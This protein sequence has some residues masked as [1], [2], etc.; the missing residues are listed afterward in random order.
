MTTSDPLLIYDGDCGVCTRAAHWVEARSDV[1]IR[2][3]EDLT[4]DET[5]R[6][7]TDWRQ[8]AHFLVGDRV[9]SCG[10]AMERAYARTDHVGTPLL[11]V[12]RRLPGYALV[13]EAGYRQFADHRPLVARLLPR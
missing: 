9:Y 8:C 11:G 10:E 5:K 13:R 12:A 1:E 7:P 3:F 6:L 2:P 4:D